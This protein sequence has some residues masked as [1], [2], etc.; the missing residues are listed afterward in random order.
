MLGADKG[1]TAAPRLT[2]SIKV[3]TDGALCMS[4]TL[5]SCAQLAQFA[6]EQPVTGN[7]ERQRRILTRGARHSEPIATIS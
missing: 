3:K 6:S 4:A 2:G 7:A 1:A 5:A